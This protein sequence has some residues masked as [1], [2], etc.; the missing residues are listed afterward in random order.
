MDLQLLVNEVV[1]KQINKYVSIQ[2]NQ[3][4]SKGILSIVKFVY[5][6]VKFKSLKVH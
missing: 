5:F 6:L 1:Y 2:V 3:L 4:V